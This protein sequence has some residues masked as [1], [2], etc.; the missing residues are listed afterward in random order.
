[1]LKIVRD[2]SEFHS[3][4]EVFSPESPGFPGE[5]RIALRKSLIAEEVGETLRAIDDRNLV[6]VADGI[7]DSIVVLV[8]TALEFGIDLTAVWGEVHRSNMSK[9][10]LCSD[11]EG[12]GIDDS[13]LVECPNCKGRGRVILRRE[14]GKILKPPTWTPPNV[15]AYLSS[16]KGAGDVES[17]NAGYH[18][19][20]HTENHGVPLG[21]LY[22]NWISEARRE[23]PN[24]LEFLAGF[25]EGRKDY[26]EANRG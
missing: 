24:Y 26:A 18:R 12:F 14:D 10:P 23:R 5:D 21:K 22:S 4:A 6:E 7:A 2:V 8:G 15:A 9:F 16:G 17:Y 19:G 20:L 25:E 13:T 11:C 3:A 1:M